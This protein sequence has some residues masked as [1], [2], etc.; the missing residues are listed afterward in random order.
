MPN[1]R[2]M[3]YILFNKITNIIDELKEVQQLT[4]EIYMQSDNKI[5]KLTISEEDKDKQ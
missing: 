4:E 2:N 5:I 1:Y 3:Y